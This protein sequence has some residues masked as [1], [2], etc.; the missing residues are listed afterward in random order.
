MRRARRVA[1][2]V[3]AVLVVL[4]G[5]AWSAVRW[6]WAAAADEA[7][8]TEWRALSEGETVPRGSHVRLDMTTGERFVRSAPS[9]EREAASTA[10][11]APPANANANANASDTAPNTQ[12]DGTTVGSRLL[13]ALEPVAAHDPVLATRLSEIRALGA[14]GSPEFEDATKK[15]WRER[16][17]ILAGPKPTNATSDSVVNGNVDVTKVAMPYLLEAVKH[18]AT[19]PVE[20]RV[21]ALE[22]I[23]SRVQDLDEA[24][25]F[26]QMGGLDVCVAALQ[27]EDHRVRALAAHV[28]GSAVKSTE[29]L[30][31]QLA[32]HH[33][34]PVHKLMDLLDHAHTEAKGLFALGALVR[35]SSTSRAKA[36]EHPSFASA[37]VERMSK[38]GPVQDKA[39]ALIGDLLREGAR[40]EP[41]KRAGLCAR[42]QVLSAT[43]AT[44]TS[45]GGG[46]EGGGAT[47]TNK[48][49]T[50]LRGEARV[51]CGLS[52]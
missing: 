45:T 27:D 2:F 51:V 10:L 38:P 32:S 30:Q 37:L 23:E 19:H 42:L 43:A 40:H 25:A 8:A 13:A 14:P 26:A 47:T 44:T 4:L 52:D 5:V 36:E 39:L 35:G 15:L 12:S 18:S 24:H 9:S 34:E 17:D 48:H 16:Q 7:N 21:K 6:A 49:L 46:D 11:S 3:A 28:L 22:E 50:Y 1:W 29:K 31:E 41:F 20:K 33:G